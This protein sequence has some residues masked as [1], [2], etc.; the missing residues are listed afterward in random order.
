MCELISNPRRNGEPERREAVRRSRGKVLNAR[1]KRNCCNYFAFDSNCVINSKSFFIRSDS[2][3]LVC[4]S[5]CVFSELPP[6]TRESYCVQRS[7]SDD[8]LRA[9]IVEIAVVKLAEH[10]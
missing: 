7:A 5:N 1:A 9:A 3:A 2:A 10:A 6:S 4:A 8:R